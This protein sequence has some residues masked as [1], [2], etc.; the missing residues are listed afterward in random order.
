ML[1]GEDQVAAWYV[2]MLLLELNTEITKITKRM[3][4]NRNSSVRCRKTQNR[5]LEKG[6]VAASRPVTTTAEHHPNRKRS[7]LR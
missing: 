6:M 5:K 2:F 1:E 3:N 4:E 7:H